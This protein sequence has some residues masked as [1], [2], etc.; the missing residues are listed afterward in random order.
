M[1]SHNIVNEYTAIDGSQ[2][3]HD[4][5]GNLSGDPNGYH[6]FYDYENR[7]VKITDRS[8]TEVADY[9]YGAKIDVN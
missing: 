1:Y 8:Q 6:Y 7:L 9:S 5:A 2:V 4:D 3:N